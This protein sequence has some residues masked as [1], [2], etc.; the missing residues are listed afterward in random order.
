MSVR[1]SIESMICLPRQAMA[2]VAMHRILTRTDQM[3]VMERQQQRLRMNRDRAS[4]SN[5]FGP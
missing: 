4:L 3:V 1:W 2:E 5:I